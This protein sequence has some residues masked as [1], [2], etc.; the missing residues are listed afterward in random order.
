MVV[1]ALA[2]LTGAACPPSA[3]SS[4]G[5]RSPGRACSPWQVLAP[6]GP[7]IGRGRAAGALAVVAAVVAVVGVPLVY[8][9]ASAASISTPMFAAV[10]AV[11]IALLG[12]LLVPHFRVPCRST[13][14][15]RPASPRRWSPWPASSALQLTSR[16]TAPTAHGPNYIQYTLDADTGHATWLSAGTATDGWTAQFFPDGYTTTRQ[17]FS[18]GYFFDQDFDVIEAPAPPVDL[19]RPRSDRPRRHRRRRSADAAAPDHLTARRPDGPPRPHPA[20]RPRCRHRRRCS[21]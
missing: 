9:L 11:F 1:A 15:G 20:R 12:S 14:L 6:S 16:I 10:I 4:C 17:A 19:A 2:L 8:L 18:P 13:G 3:M 5:P 7:P 21:R